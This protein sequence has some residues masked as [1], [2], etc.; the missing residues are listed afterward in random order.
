MRLFL[1]IAA[2]GA[3]KGSVV[4]D[5]GAPTNS[6]PSTPALSITE[7]E[8]GGLLCATVSAPL[9]PDGDAVS[10]SYAWEA[11]GGF[12]A[13]GAAISPEDAARGRVWTCTAVSADAGG[14]GAPSSATYEAS[15]PVP[16]QYAFRPVMNLAYGVDLEALPDGTLLVATILG[17]LLR[18]DPE[19]GTTLGTLTV[20]APEDELLSVALDPRFGDGE[21]DQV[22]TWTSQ[23]CRLSATTLDPDTMSAVATWE[24]AEYACDTGGGHSSGQLA[25]WQGETDE[26][27]LYLA[28][29]PVEEL[30]PQDDS[31][32]GQGLYAWTVDLDVGALNPALP[33]VFTNLAQVA[34]GL[35]NP[36]RLIDCGPCLCMA[37]AGHDQIE[38][39][40]LYCGD[41]PN[42]GAGVVEGPDPDG[43][44]D[45]PIRYW[46]HDDTALVD[47][48][49]DGGGELRFV[50]V[51]A[52]GL[53]ASGAGYSGRLEGWTLYG[54]FY[55]G[56]IRAFKVEDDGSVG[57]DVRLAHRRHLMAMAE[58]P[59]GS[60]WALDLGGTLQRLILRGDRAVVGEVGQPLSETSYPDGGTS[61]DVRYPLWSNG[62]DKDRM[63]Q[64]PEGET[65]DVSDPD[66]WVWPVGAKLW[67]TFTQDGTT[68]ETRLLEKT[69]DGWI[70]GVYLWDGDDAYLTDGTRQSLVLAGGGYTVPSTETCAFCH[71][72][73]PG[74]EWPLGPEPF[75]LGEF[76]LSE[77]APL[78]SGDPGP[79]PEVVGE[80]DPEA[81]EI[82]GELHGNCAFC[83]W[84][85]GL[86]S[87]I[88]ETRI[89]LRYDATD[90]GLID[91]RVNYYDDLTPYG[92]PTEY[93]VV[94][95]DPDQSVLLD[96]L[97]A[98]DMP[99]VATWR[100]DTALT[101]ALGHWIL[102]L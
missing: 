91:G 25:W 11:D 8:D 29:G 65:I 32:D 64:L 18:V 98:T 77:L 4:P 93:L 26:P 95:G 41:G 90:T 87:T 67:K 16:G 31:D 23:S 13:S 14:P 39:I 3:D 2:C 61:Y 33:A 35:R 80:T 102:G 71:E 45:D 19:T 24:L 69:E 94:P 86:A 63:V 78:L 50:H 97:A 56:W 85:G 21:H 47:Q 59:D 36:W 10:T 42:Y 72:A 52:L 44:Y 6:R 76:G 92:P 60:I 58:T 68:V 9:D 53:R 84:E 17:E 30:D 40:D 79:V 48:D 28:V 1:L 49:L 55:D 83:H 7:D 82:R 62:A 12:V 89:D 51:P 54:E 100:E 73:T 22:Y 74:R 5:T 43:I 57:P 101:E 34:T 66:A 88:S 99:P 96:I 81:V 38:E 70:P 27:A 46:D 20:A 37:D 75:Q 15:G